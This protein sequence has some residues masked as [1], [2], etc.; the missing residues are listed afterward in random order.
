MSPE[1][2]HK[3]LI[4]RAE[5]NNPLMDPEMCKSWLAEL[6]HKMDM[7]ILIGPFSAYCDKAGNKG[8]TGAVIIETSHMAIHIWDEDSPSIIQLDVYTC[9]ELVKETIFEHLAIMEP[10][11]L[12]YKYLDRLVDLH[13]VDSGFEVYGDIDGK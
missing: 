11:K 9:G 2:K 5:V 1:I 4:V 13:E 7:K 8:V 6:V 12:S 3:H 10:Q